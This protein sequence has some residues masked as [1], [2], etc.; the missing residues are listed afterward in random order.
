MLKYHAEDVYE[1][2]R[3]SKEVKTELLIMHAR[4]SDLQVD[5]L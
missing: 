5:E 4:K 3:T 2:S 1:V